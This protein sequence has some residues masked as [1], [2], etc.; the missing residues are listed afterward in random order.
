MLDQLNV[1]PER[2]RKELSPRQQKALLLIATTNTPDHLY[3]T[4]HQV[5]RTLMPK[6]VLAALEKKDLIYSVRDRMGEESHANETYVYVLLSGRGDA[7]VQ[8]IVMASC[9]ERK[10]RRIEFSEVTDVEKLLRYAVQQGKEEGRN[11]DNPLSDVVYLLNAMSAYDLVQLATRIPAVVDVNV[12]IE[13]DITCDDYTDAAE[14]LRIAFA[15]MV[16][17]HLKGIG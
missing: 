17:V 11:D 6:K 12:S 14:V 7:V 9:E 15:N 5:P 10:A 4:H 13:E 1:G 2:I 8:A 16:Q 3:P